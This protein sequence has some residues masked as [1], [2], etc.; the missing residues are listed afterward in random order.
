MIGCLWPLG[1]AGRVAREERGGVPLLVIQPA[2]G[3]EGPSAD[4]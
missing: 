1:A 4:A 2:L 3:G